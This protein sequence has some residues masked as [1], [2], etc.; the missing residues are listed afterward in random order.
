MA[1]VPR[2]RRARG[3]RP[4]G[5][6]RQAGRGA[7]LLGGDGRTVPGGVLDHRR[8]DSALR[9]ALRPERAGLHGAG[10]PVRQRHPPARHRHPGPGHALPADVGC[11]HRPGGGADGGD[12][13]LFGRLRHGPARRLLRRLGRHGDLADLRHRPELSGDHPLPDHHRP[14]R[15]VGDQHHHRGDL[16]RRPADH[17]H[18]PRADLGHQEPRVRDGGADPRRIVALRHGGGDPAERARALDRRCLPAHGLHHQSRSASW[19]FW[20]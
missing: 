10:R 20:S 15:R 2:H 5:L 16:H 9:R 4:A 1:T 7:P 8:A 18:R 3:R 19:A 12:H 14:V 13:R 11:A 6:L 17:A